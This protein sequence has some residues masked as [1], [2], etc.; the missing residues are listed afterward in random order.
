M[1]MSTIAIHPQERSEGRPN[2]GRKQ[3]NLEE[4]NPAFLK[5][6]T[7]GLADLKAGRFVVIRRKHLRED[8]KTFFAST[9]GKS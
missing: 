4:A 2:E 8:L 9:A 1:H 7:K 3:L 5:A 6:T